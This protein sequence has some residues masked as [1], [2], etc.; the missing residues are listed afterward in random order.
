MPS[1]NSATSSSSDRRG[2][3]S[4]FNRLRD[5]ALFDDV[6]QAQHLEQAVGFTSV[7]C[8]DRRNNL[9]VPTFRCFYRP[10]FFTQRQ[11]NRLQITINAA[12]GRPPERSIL[13]RTSRVTRSE[14]DQLEVNCKIM[15]I[16]IIMC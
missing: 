2:E 14:F 1:S 13:S 9:T 16:I 8:P 7:P 5:I 3:A 12:N 10:N 11:A 15:R 6:F 4:E